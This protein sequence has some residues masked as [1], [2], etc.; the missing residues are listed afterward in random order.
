M[1]GF[2][3]TAEHIH[4]AYNGK[5]G[6]RDASLHVKRGDIYGLA[7]KNGAGKTT[8]LRILTGLIPRYEGKVTMRGEDASPI[9]IA[10]V[11]SSPSL[12]L[13]MSAYEN[14][15]VQAFLLGECDVERIEQTLRRVGLADSDCKNKQVRK[16]SQGMMQ[17]LKLGMALLEN[18]DILILDEP[19]NGLDPDGIVELRELLLHLNQTCGTTIL[20][21]SHILS[22]L[23]H[24]ATCFGILHDGVIV[25]E[26]MFQD[27]V[28]EGMTLEALYMQST[29]GGSR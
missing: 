1:S 27:L 21:S 22:E 10:A 23:E 24:V 2:I 12:F 6:L 20:L 18:P 28:Q 5:R 26:M 7:G 19:L 16:F 15:K 17:R 3:L 8:L 11:I 9:K 14:M 13:N 29:K 4:K 25:K